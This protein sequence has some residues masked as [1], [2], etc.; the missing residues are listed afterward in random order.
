MGIWYAHGFT[1]GDNQIT[2]ESKMI[3]IA[4]AICNI[5]WPD[6][7]ETMQLRRLENHCQ[8]EVT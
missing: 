5:C 1:A 8:A 2:S 3:G 6:P 4:F 7:T